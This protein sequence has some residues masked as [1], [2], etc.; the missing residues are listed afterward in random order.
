MNTDGMEPILGALQGI[1]RSLLGNPGIELHPDMK[2]G[3]LDGWDS[4]AN[5][6]ILLACEARWDFR[7]SA[8]EID[9]VR[10]V[11]DLARA[12]GAKLG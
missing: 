7:F 4:F 10:S 11:G 9:R 5:V 1:F 8:V 2:T 6:E 12:I 3:E